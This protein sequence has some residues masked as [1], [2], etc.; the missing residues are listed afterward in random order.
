MF[1]TTVVSQAKE[2]PFWVSK[3]EPLSAQTFSKK[4]LLLFVIDAQHVTVYSP[5]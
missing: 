5:R 3:S 4:P 1:E 2:A